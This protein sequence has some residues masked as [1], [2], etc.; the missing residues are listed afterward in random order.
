MLS[1]LNSEK[2]IE[3]SRVKSGS[4]EVPDQNMNV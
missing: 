2:I 4:R 3:E 1:N